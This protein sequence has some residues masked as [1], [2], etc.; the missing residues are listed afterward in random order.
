MRQ[1]YWPSSSVP[2]KGQRKRILQHA[3]QRLHS[4]WRRASSGSGSSRSEGPLDEAPDLAPQL[5]RRHA[6]S[7]TSTPFQARRKADSSRP[8]SGGQGDGLPCCHSAGAPYGLTPHEPQEAARAAVDRRRRARPRRSRGRGTGRLRRRPGPGAR[9]A[10]AGRPPGRRRRGVA[11]RRRL[12][13]HHRLREL[14]RRPHPPRPPPRAPA[15]P[16]PQPRRRGG[17]APRRGRDAGPHAPAGQRPG[18]G[19]LRHPPRDPRAAGRHAQPRRPSGRPL[20]GLGGR[21]RRPRPPRPPRPAPRRRGRVRLR[22]PPAPRARRPSLPPA[23]RR[24]PSSP[25]K[26]WRS[27]TAPS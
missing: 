20:T 10:V 11:G 15:Q 25:R 16:H 24:S 7:R 3:P 12:R 9:E 19:V 2:R 14:R 22:G 6:S 4:P 21:Q 18:Q 26:A 8:P 17:G 13:R 1:V 23:S 27:S 5:Q